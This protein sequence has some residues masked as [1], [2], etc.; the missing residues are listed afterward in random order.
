MPFEVSIAILNHI[1]DRHLVLLNNCG[2]WP[3]F[4]KPAECRGTGPRL[5]E[6]LLRETPTLSDCPPALFGRLP[7]R[8]G[9]NGGAD[10]DHGEA[11]RPT[12]GAGRTAEPVEHVADRDRAEKAGREPG[13]R[14]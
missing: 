2:H 8:P 14:V 11:C 7:H 10:T 12:Q 5:A 4:E 13:E 9:G 3:P 6:G 1:A